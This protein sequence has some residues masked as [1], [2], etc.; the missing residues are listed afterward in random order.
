MFG[1]EV[2][3]TLRRGA[4]PILL[5]K[6]IKSEVIGSKLYVLHIDTKCHVTI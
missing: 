6:G 5:R 2:K 3:V 4:T 1:K